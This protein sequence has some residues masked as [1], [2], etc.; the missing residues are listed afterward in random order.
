MVSEIQVCEQALSDKEVEYL[1]V[2]GSKLD[3]FYLLPKIHKRSADVVCRPVIS[4]CDTVT[5]HI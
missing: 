3:R 2:R 4:N 1:Q 5:E